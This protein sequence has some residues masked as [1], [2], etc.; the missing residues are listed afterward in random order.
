MAATNISCTT[1]SDEFFCPTKWQLWEQ[2]LAL[3]P[4][5]RAWQSH[6]AVNEPDFGPESQVGTFE[7]GRTGV[8]PAA[9]V[10]LTVMQQYWLAFAEVLEYF[11]QRA[12]ALLDEMFCATT[13]EL[14]GEWGTDYGF[15]DDCEPW[16]SLCEKVA[17]QGGATCAYL[18]EL[19]ARLGYE[20]E[21][22][23][24]APDGASAGCFVADCD[25]PCPCEPN[26]IYITVHLPDTPEQ[27]AAT[28]FEAGAAVADCTPPC[29]PAPEQL[30]C[31]IER[32]KPAHVKAIYEVI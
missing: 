8:A 21:C 2:L 24:C 12:C 32:F 28:Q 9:G 11:H 22:R 15:P 30:I 26:V 16:S 19:A 3:L 13:N 31:L 1:R 4:R 18:A 10:R 17:A 20:I 5:G 23:D 7:V 25:V 6:E 14:R 29:I 27:I